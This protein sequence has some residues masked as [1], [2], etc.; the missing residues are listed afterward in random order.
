MTFKTH[1]F[2]LFAE[3]LFACHLLGLCKSDDI[4]LVQVLSCEKI[5]LA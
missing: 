3:L 2:A 1:G 5:Q 4:E